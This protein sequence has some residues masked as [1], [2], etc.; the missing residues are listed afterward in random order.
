[1]TV[2]VL[3]CQYRPCPNAGKNSDRR[4]SVAIKLK[5]RSRTRELIAPISR[6]AEGADFVFEMPMG[7]GE[8]F[9]TETGYTRGLVNLMS[10]VVEGDRLTFPI[11]VERY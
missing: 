7:W 10:R 5:Y 6:I 11:E 2:S 4:G 9:G 3:D 8:L 1:M